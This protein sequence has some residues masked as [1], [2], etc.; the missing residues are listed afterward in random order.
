[1]SMSPTIF[2]FISAALSNL[3]Y[4]VK[5]STSINWVVTTESKGQLL[6]TQDA[7]LAFSGIQDLPTV[8]LNIFLA[9]DT[10]YQTMFGFGSSLEAST[11]YNMNLLGPEERDVLMRKLFSTSDGIGFNLMRLTVGTSDY[12]LPPFYSYNDRPAG[13]ADPTLEYF[14]TF[15]DDSYIAPMIQEALVKSRSYM[16]DDLRAAQDGLLFF[17]SPWSGPSWMK[18]TGSLIGGELLDQ[19]MPQYAQYLSKFISA[20][21]SQYDIDIYAVTPQNEPNVI[22][23]DYPS[24]FLSPEKEAELIA[25][26]LGPEMD[27]LGVKIW[28]Y[29]DNW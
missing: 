5:A 13:R 17:A 18:S 7:A 8:P 1:M 23:S 28:G 20:Y 19:Y 11:C 6:S 4:E 22:R 15:W 25:N 12:C 26:Y 24:S 2:L 9:S 10:K 16:E 14:N 29:D 27:K 3:L 21:S